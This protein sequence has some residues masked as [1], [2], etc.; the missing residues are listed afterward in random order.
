M[1]TQ[2]WF[3]KHRHSSLLAVASD[4]FTRLSVVGV[5][6]VAGGRTGSKTASKSI[7]FHRR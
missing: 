7:A 3:E 6:N 1:N 4:A 2:C 5:G